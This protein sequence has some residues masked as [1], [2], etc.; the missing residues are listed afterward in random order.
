MY[1]T[2][3]VASSRNSAARTMFTSDRTDSAAM[4]ISYPVL[5]SSAWDDSL[6]DTY[7]PPRTECSH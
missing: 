6:A 5:P 2:V 1:T 3:W 7:D 4:K